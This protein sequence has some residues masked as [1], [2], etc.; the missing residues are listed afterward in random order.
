MHIGLSPLQSGRSFE[1]TAQER[2]RTDALGFD[3]VRLGEHHN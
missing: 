2:E 1:A 3:S